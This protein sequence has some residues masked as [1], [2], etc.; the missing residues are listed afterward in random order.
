MGKRSDMK[1]KRGLVYLKKKDA[2]AVL[3]AMMKPLTEHMEKKHEHSC[4][5]R[6]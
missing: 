1:I 6:G 4:T 2:E 5:A 3:K